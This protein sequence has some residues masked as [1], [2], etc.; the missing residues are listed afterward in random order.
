[1]Q[2]STSHILQYVIK[3]IS[4]HVFSSVIYLA[5]FNLRWLNKSFPLLTPVYRSARVVDSVGAVHT[6][7]VRSRDDN[8][9]VWAFSIGFRAQHFAFCVRR[10]RVR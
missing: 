3:A 4:K 8:E 9:Y 2:M 7:T 6:H 10:R 5:L 1:M